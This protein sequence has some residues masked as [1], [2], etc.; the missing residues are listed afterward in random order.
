MAAI[1]TDLRLSLRVLG[2]Q[3]GFTCAAVVV[4]ALGIGANTAVFAVIDGLLIR[5]L[6]GAN[7]GPA[8]LGL[9]SKDS[10]R[11]DRYRAFS[12]PDFVDIRSSVTTLSSVAASAVMEVGITEGDTTRRSFVAAVSSNFFDTLGVRPARGRGFS[13]DEERLVRSDLVVVVSD[14]YWRTKGS[15]PDILGTQVQINGRA[16]T[17]VGVAP[18]RFTGFS[19]AISPEV[20]LP[21]GATTRP[22]RGDHELLLAGRPREGVARETIDAE[23]GQIAGRLASAYPAENENQTIVTAPLPRTGISTEPGS[24]RG[25]V[26]V[27]VV[28]MVM[29]GIVLLVACLNLAN[30]L[31]ARATARQP[32]IAIRLALGASRGA[33]I[34][35]L[36]TE[37][38]VL[39]L[40][41]GALGLVLAYGATTAL[42]ESLAPL[43][44]APIEIESSPDWRVMTV[45]LLLAAVATIVFALGPARRLT[46]PIV[47]NSLRE[48]RTSSAQGRMRLLGPRNLLL[49]SQLALSLALL[50]VGALFVRSAFEAADATPGFPFDHKLLVEVDPALGAY[51]A[52]QSAAV[53]R[54]LL[55]RLRSVPG[56]EAVSM[57]SLV[58]F[59]GV[60]DGGPVERV[61][62]TAG[63]GHGQRDPVAAT[64]VVIGAGYFTS[65][66]LRVLSG[67]DFTPEEAEGTVARQVVI[68][69]EFLAQRLFPSRGDNPV[70]QFVRLGSSESAS[71][72]PPLQIVGLV[73]G[74]HGDLMKHRNAPHVYLPFGSRPRSQMYYHVRTA[75]GGPDAA[76][77]LQAIRLEIRAYD[78]HVPVLTASSFE[79][80]AHRSTTLWLFKAAAR[81]FSVFACA[82]LL[83][84]IVGI[85]GVNAYMVARRTREIG[86]RLAVGASPRDVIRL[87]LE[88]AA[89]VATVG[90][91]GGLGLAFILGSVVRSM[92]YDVA[93][94]DPVAWVSAALLLCAAVVVASYVPARRATTIAPVT[95]LRHE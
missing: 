92:L 11:A 50:V 36:L 82:A 23:L 17:I 83:L 3:P 68:I 84:A 43:M 15:S 35:Q 93:A 94:T 34:R 57:A 65:L 44:T 24:D 7:A 60:N 59:G 86:I 80:F 27:S 75:A 87:V 6:P 69:D 28:L 66:G 78:S 9:Y 4:L 2:K 56:V 76:T 25:L 90:S 20:W 47:M 5:P 33:L 70:G 51:S 42:I 81:V 1:W 62:D 73:P 16:F 30:M 71:E 37:G 54:G 31:L 67:R 14:A 52:E 39:A 12:Y 55:P 91:I 29:S 77:M 72:R 19:A 58:P 13:A 85:Y 32:E 63:T 8:L 22:S 40:A 74:I 10:R 41:G 79:E 18:P 61:T 26:T 45:T 95:A 64:H 53:H 89:V 46:R 49:A 48:E 21:L 88:D 38:F